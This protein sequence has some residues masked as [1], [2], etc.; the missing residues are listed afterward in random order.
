MWRLL[1]SLVI[2]TLISGP[3]FAGFTFQIT[4]ASGSIGAGGSANF[5]IQ[6]FKDTGATNETITLSG[7]SFV[8]EAGSGTISFSFAADPNGSVTFAPLF[9]SVSSATIGQI[10]AT[11]SNLAQ[12]GDIRSVQ[13][14]ATVTGTNAGTFTSN[15]L[16]ITAVPEPS[17]LALV[18]LVAVGVFAR[19]R[20]RASV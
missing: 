13:F 19:R 7:A 20:V 5:T 6:A 3:A 8:N 11:A 14:E 12:F 16:T 1:S 15:V 4:P 18:G 2:A 9:G 17:S 10:T